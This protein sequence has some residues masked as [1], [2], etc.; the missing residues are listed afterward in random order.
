MNVILSS[1]SESPIYEQIFKQIKEQIVTGILPSEYQLPSIRAMAKD[2]RVGVVTIKRAYE[3]LERAH[4]IVTIP[5]RGCFV[6]KID[7]DQS[8]RENLQEIKESLLKIKDFADGVN[9]SKTDIIEI[10]DEIYGGNNE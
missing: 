3:E 2:L 1:L 5:G 8:K 9:I 7:L 10:F 4:L 6:N